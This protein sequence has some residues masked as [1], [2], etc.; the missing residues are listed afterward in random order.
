MHILITGATGFIGR[1]I[2]KELAKKTHKLRALIRPTSKLIH[3]K[4]IK[5]ELIVGDIADYDSVKKACEGIDLVYHCAGCV[6]NKNKNLLESVNIKGT[7]NICRGSLEQGVKR[8]VYAS[9]VAV[10][11]GNQAMLLTDELPY[12]HT[13]IYGWSKVE[14][15]KI[16]VRYR[17]KGLP[18]AIIRPCAI[19]GPGEP[20][21]LDLLLKLISFRLLPVIGKGNHRWHLGYIHN[22]VQIFLLA[23]KRQSALSKTFIAADIEA[24]TVN[25]VFN[26]MADTLGVKRPRH[27]P[28]ILAYTCAKCCDMLNRVSVFSIPFTTK[29]IDSFKKERIFDVSRAVNELGYKPEITARQALELTVREWMKTKE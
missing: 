19:Y 4:D 27:I 28:D 8:V 21:L 9:S 2:I 29:N 1:Y 15:E 13:N 3:F 12:A 24:L 25:E 10:V 23:A 14:A 11:S 5:I 7:E 22:I 16:A 18:I 20:H 6:S 17:E 26:I